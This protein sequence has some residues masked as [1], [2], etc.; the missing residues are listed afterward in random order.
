MLTAVLLSWFLSVPAPASVH[1]AFS[2]LWVVNLEKSD[3]GS[4][5]TPKQV[6]FAIEQLDNS[7]SVWEVVMSRTGRVVSY[8]QMSF[9]KERCSNRGTCVTFPNTGA[10]EEWWEFS[11]TGEL[12][13]HREAR[14][15]VGLVH[16]RLVLTPSAQTLE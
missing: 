3:W 16:Q 7:L 6:I 15:G 4:V 12:I 11:E 5:P 10:E 9:T 13:I 8:R 2:G 14:L 1:S